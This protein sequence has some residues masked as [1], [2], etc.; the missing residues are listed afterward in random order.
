MRCT[1]CVAQQTELNYTNIPM[2][3]L[4]L[5]FSE[6]YHVQISINAQ[7][8]NNCL[9]SIQE[10]FETLDQAMEKLAL[11]CNLVVKKIGNVY[12]FRR[13][14]S[15]RVYSSTSPSIP[16]KYLFQGVVLNLISEEPLPF[17][18]IET[19]QKSLIC[20]AQGRFSFYANLPNVKIKI[21]H[22]GYFPLERN[23]ENG[24]HLLL[25]LNSNI[26]ILQEV[27]VQ[28]SEGTDYASTRVDVGR[29]K[30]NN[31]NKT[32]VPG[33]YSNLL[34]NA[35]RMCPGIMSSG[36]SVSDF[37]VW[38]SSPGQTNV[39]FDGINLFN[40]S[41]INDD[42]GRINP[43]LIKNIEV[44]KGGYNVDV[45]D[46]VG[47][48]LLVDGKQGN[49]DS[50][51][52][53]L[54]ANTRI[55]STYVSIPIGKSGTVLQLGGRKTYTNL[56]NAM[57]SNSQRQAFSIPKYNY[58]DVNIKLTGRLQNGDRIQ[59]S[60][61]MGADKYEESLET[62]NLISYGNV[63]NI[64]AHQFGNSL[65][66][67]KTWNTGG[68]MTITV[69]QS[70]YTSLQQ[71]NSQFSDSL[72]WFFNQSK[73]DIEDGIQEFSTRV[74]HQF[75]AKGNQDLV[76]GVGFIHN[77]TAMKVTIDSHEIL[78]ENKELNR[79]ELLA[80]DQLHFGKQLRLVLGLKTDIPLSS[81]HVYLQPRVNGTW[82]MSKRLQ[83]NFGWG[84]YT[85]FAHKLAFTDYSSSPNYVWSIHKDTP[86]QSMHN[87]VGFSYHKKNIEITVE[88]YY[89]TTRHMQMVSL[90]PDSVLHTRTHTGV[91][92]GSDVWI[93]K[94]WKNFDAQ[95]G[96]S[97][98]ENTENYT[99][100]FG[101]PTTQ[102]APHNQ[103]HE[104]KLG[105]IYHRPKFQCSA[106]YVYGS[107]FSGWVTF[108]DGQTI[109]SSRFDIAARYR[110]M[111]K[112]QQLDIGLSIL[113]VF[114][115][116]NV[117]YNQVIIFEDGNVSQ[118]SATPFLPSLNLRLGF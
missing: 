107:G 103:L 118:S 78:S 79:M 10:K 23:L 95:I 60:S 18:T 93:K 90:D 54:V 111:D 1:V 29:I 33:N 31:L 42:I 20:D 27:E 105:A 94:R 73:E 84:I 7:E 75:A 36:E 101:E 77:A 53:E 86:L 9:V 100:I 14:E 104:L 5:D 109:A 66:Y 99:D 55:I 49:P 106:N 2:N 63:Q 44:F 3:D 40:S 17:S 57:V 4:L 64:N 38:G 6:R 16:I 26:Q 39:I 88:G 96:Y 72:L 91:T 70:Q 67:H 117:L 87:V 58:G 112:K 56:F 43:L 41:G 62:G 102:F 48:V 12:T 115:T 22:L 80:K 76:L 98:S 113:N 71:S 30:L 46:R 74:K 51:S 37:I 24:H 34:F 47:G 85:Q 92:F 11:S 52:G 32:L 65:I 69:A 68:L 45:G 83:F 97:I 81:M 89:K 114:D 116:K 19:P 15:A 13:K 110:L 28:L 82:N 8:S 59:F 35:T 21:R 25:K 50:L 108:N 61:I